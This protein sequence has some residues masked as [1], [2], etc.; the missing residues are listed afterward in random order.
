[1]KPN[2]ELDVHMGLDGKNFDC[3][4]CHTTRLHQIAGRT[5]ATPAA[6]HRKSLVED[7]TISKITCES[8]HTRTPHRPGEK[9]NDHTDKVACQS[10]HIP[11]FA[12]VNPTKIYWDWSKAGEKKDGK[13][14]KKK[15]P[16][17]K[18][19]YDTLKGEMVWEQ[20]V[21]PDYYWYN[22]SIDAL[23]AVDMIDPSKPVQINWP[24]G[25]REDSD[26]RIAPFKTHRGKQPYDKINKT[27]LIPHLFGKKGSGAYW[28]DWEWK[29]ALASGMQKAGLPFSGEFDWVETAYV[30][31]ITHMVA[32]KEK[33]LSCTACHA[34]T[35]S[36]LAKLTGFYMPGRNASKVIDFTGWGVTLACLIG[37][38]IHALGRVFARGNGRKEN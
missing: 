19:A 17:G 18:P 23:T 22:G 16:L 35:G 8:C 33:S 4:R 11:E 1:M 3:V 2:K 24:L 26:A 12:R 27:L 32:P 13:P 36:R 38:L 20:N 30:F 37:V 29:N 7:D 31:P 15:G 10:C 14:F 6:E 34:K 21:V 25:S 9:P 5:Y 28:G